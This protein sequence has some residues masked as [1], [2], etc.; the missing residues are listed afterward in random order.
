MLDDL[1]PGEDEVDV[2]VVERQRRYNTEKIT[3]AGDE[4]E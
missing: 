3:A 2:P 1:V 4:G